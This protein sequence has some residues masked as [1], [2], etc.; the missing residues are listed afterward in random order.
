MGKLRE[1][2]AGARPAL[3][4]G[5]ALRDRY[6]SPFSPN[7]GR[8]DPDA[9]RTCGHRRPCGRT[10]AHRPKAT[11]QL[12]RPAP[13]TGAMHPTNLLNALRSTSAIEAM[14]SSS[15][16]ACSS[17]R[18][19]SAACQSAGRVHRDQRRRWPSAFGAP[20]D[21]ASIALPPVSTITL[22]DGEAHKDLATLNTI[23]DALLERAPI[24]ETTLFALGGGVVGDITG[25]A[26]ACY[27]RG[28]PTCKCRRPCWPRSIRRSAAR[29]RSTI[30]SA[31]T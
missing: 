3:S 13:Y 15:A 12:S 14:T 28:V 29:R 6:R 26:A 2:Y 25:F 27:M 31:R 23:F 5:S 10:L 16:P 22:P 4:A 8:H 9:T 30:R 20:V 21:D 19:P 1:L 18:R 24:D 17:A 11:R 7:A